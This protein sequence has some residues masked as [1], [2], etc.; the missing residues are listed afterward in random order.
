MVVVMVTTL[1]N[2]VTMVVVAV[3]VAIVEAFLVAMK[4]MR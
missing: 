1:V 4:M 3:Q 2:E